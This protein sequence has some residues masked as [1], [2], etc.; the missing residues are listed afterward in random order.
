MHECRAMC[1]SCVTLSS[2]LPV[3]IFLEDVNMSISFT[4]EELVEALKSMTAGK[5]PGPDGI[6]PGVP[7]P[8]GNA[9]AKWLCQY[10]STSLKRCQIHRIWRKATV[11]ALPKSNKPKNDHKSNRPISLLCIPFKLL[12]RMIHAWTYQSIIDPIRSYLTS[13]LASV[14]DDQP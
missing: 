7:L 9:A 14:K 1:V 11:I 6:H 2:T 8:A 4:T 12:E 13:K 5:A 10:I 3:F